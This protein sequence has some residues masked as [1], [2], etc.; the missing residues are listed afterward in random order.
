MDETANAAGFLPL[1]G[2]RVL[3]RLDGATAQYDLSDPANGL[4]AS[5]EVLILTVLSRYGYLLA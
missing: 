4:P 3:V 5:V 2:N 1:G